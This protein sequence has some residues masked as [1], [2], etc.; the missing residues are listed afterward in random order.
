[1]PRPSVL[2]HWSA[3]G[4][5]WVLRHTV[6]IYGHSPRIAHPIVTSYT[7]YWALVFV[8]R[9]YRIGTVYGARGTARGSWICLQ[10]FNSNSELTSTPL[11]P[12]FSIMFGVH[13][14]IAIGWSEVDGTMG[15]WALKSEGHCAEGPIEYSFGWYIG[16][17]P[18]VS[19]IVAAYGTDASL[20][21]VRTDETCVWNRFYVQIASFVHF[22][23]TAYMRLQ[24]PRHSYLVVLLDA[25]LQ[26]TYGY[27]S[28]QLLDI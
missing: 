3:K 26:L 18:D 4:K 16:V 9:R 28:S 1:M 12:T 20:Q 2:R 10:G 11:P 13:G 7:A 23:M 19:C 15:I 5:Y 8:N 25:H 22:P 6:L 27:L 14:C 21:I 17:A 24:R